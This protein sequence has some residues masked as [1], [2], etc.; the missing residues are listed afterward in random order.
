M[1]AIRQLQSPLLVGRDEVLALIERRLT[2]AK[3]GRG[4]LLLFAGE[5]GI[6]KSRVI[7]AAIDA[8][9]GE[10]FR[11]AKGDLSPQDQFVPLASLG[12]LA[13]SIVGPDFG[14]LGPA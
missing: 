5:A 14:D 11:Y 4:T 12:D 3:A 7:G 8:A 10:G 6:G 9:L 1:T 13:R 2:E